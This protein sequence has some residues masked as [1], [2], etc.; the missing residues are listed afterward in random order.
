MEGGGIQTIVLLWSKSDALIM[1]IFSVIFPGNCVALSITPQLDTCEKA[2]ESRSCR[3]GQRVSPPSTNYSCLC[4]LLKCL[5]SHSS[6]SF[7][8]GGG[9][10]GNQ[11]INVITAFY[12]TVDFGVVIN[13]LIS[14]ESLFV[15]LFKGA[16]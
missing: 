1:K 13:R 9:E 4:S 3:C 10:T 2:V 16:A 12:E 5:A 11:Q 7:E 6:D 14:E 15:Q 8:V